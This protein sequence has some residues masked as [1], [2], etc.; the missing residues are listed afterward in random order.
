MREH[1]EK[2]TT[3][4][5]ATLLLLATITA[6][7]LATGVALAATLVGTDGNDL[8]NGT[9]GSDTLNV[10]KNGTKGTAGADALYGKGGND[11]L[12]G[13]SGDDNWTTTLG[14]DTDGNKI[15]AGLNGGAGDDKAYG[16]AG[17]DKMMGNAG[18][19]TID[20]SSPYSTTS[21]GDWDLAYGGSGNDTA[22]LVDGD[23]R[24]EA[25]CGEETTTDPA[26][27]ADTDTAKIDVIR[28]GSGQITDADKVY[29]CETIRNQKGNVVAQSNL[30]QYQQAA[31]A[32]QSVTAPSEPT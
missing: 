14:Y 9:S 3:M 21:P 32:G 2:E 24:D 26:A 4:R 16:G 5:R 27:P 28:D 13:G 7:L 12:Y 19:D 18:N 25:V 23:V 22:N 10:A 6:V 20:D 17:D 15:P 1:R 8:I 30:P 11:I 29:D 31:A